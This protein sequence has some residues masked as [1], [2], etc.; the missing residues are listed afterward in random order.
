MGYMLIFLFPL[1]LSTKVSAGGALSIELSLDGALSP[2]LFSRWRPLH[3]IRIQKCSYTPILLLNILSYYHDKKSS[4]KYSQPL[5][6]FILL[7]SYSST[8]HYKTP[9]K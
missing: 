3:R 4:I 8:R 5:D 9:P 1:A 6:R 7:C 2:K